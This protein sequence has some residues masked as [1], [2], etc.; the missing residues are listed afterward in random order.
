MPTAKTVTVDIIRDEVFDDAPDDTQIARWCELAQ[1]QAG[2]SLAAADARPV[3]LVVRLVGKEVSAE[4]NSHFRHKNSATNVLSFPGDLPSV[5]TDHLEYIPLGDLLICP[6]VLR[7]EA[8]EQHK[9]LADHWAHILVHGV[10]HLN[11][12]DHQNDADAEKM[13]T[14]EINILAQMAVA[15]PYIDRSIE[16]A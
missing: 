6:E 14:L 9:S 1:Q 7:T 13:E 16:T 3:Q 11:G 12:F 8:Q 15:N 4:L 10:L 5:V 2:P